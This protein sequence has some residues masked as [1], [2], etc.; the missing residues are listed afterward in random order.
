M[1]WAQAQTCLNM[2]REIEFKRNY[3]TALS[4]YMSGAAFGGMKDQQ[5]ADLLAPWASMG[6]SRTDGLRLTLTG[7]Q[8]DAFRLG[9]RRG[10]ISQRLL[11]LFS[12]K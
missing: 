1:A 5:P 2:I 7:T 8:G 11:N 12:A 10:V 4:A 6:E 3:H 9:L